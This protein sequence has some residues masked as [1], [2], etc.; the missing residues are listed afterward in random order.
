MYGIRKIPEC[1]LVKVIESCLK[2][3]YYRLEPDYSHHSIIV[4]MPMEP[5]KLDL[6]SEATQEHGRPWPVMLF[7]VFGLSNLM[8]GLNVHNDFHYFNIAI[9][10]VM[11]AAG[12]IY[13]R[14]YKPKI[15]IF[16][17]KG[18]AGRL[19]RRQTVDIRWDEISRLEMKMFEID[20]YLDSG[21]MITINLNN[22]TYRQHHELKPK[23]IEWAQSKNIAVDS[24]IRA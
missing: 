3:F 22:C 9:G 21:K 17:E 12:V 5:I 23:I 10:A 18:I 4:P 24:A 2:Y 19:S 13:L 7:M 16:D 11:I 8:Q 1:W 15:V 20:V 14:F 6:Q